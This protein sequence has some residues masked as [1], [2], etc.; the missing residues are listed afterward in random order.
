MHLNICKA[1]AKHDN[2][3]KCAFCNGFNE[4]WAYTYDEIWKYYLGHLRHLYV[5]EYMRD[6]KIEP[7]KNFVRRNQ[8]NGLF[9]K[10]AIS[11][12]SKISVNNKGSLVFSRIE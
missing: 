11:L 5:Y 8:Y 1:C 6:G 7:Y 12:L 3:D 9:S 4:N 10:N 2:E